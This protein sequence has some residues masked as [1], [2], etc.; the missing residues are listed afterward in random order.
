MIDLSVIE[1]QR[2]SGMTI[3]EIAKVNNTYEGAIYR[4]MK[5]KKKSSIPAGQINGQGTVSGTL[6]ELRSLADVIQRAIEA[7]EKIEG[8]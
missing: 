7:L 3:K 8:K 5:N 1:A 2:K 4:V 6:S